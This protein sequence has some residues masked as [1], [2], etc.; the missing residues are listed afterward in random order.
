MSLHF[1]TVIH[2]YRSLTNAVID[3]KPPQTLCA[4]TSLPARYRDP[5]TGLP[6]ANAYAF[7][8][9]KKLQRGEYKWS[10]LAG[11]YVGVGVIPQPAPA[12]SPLLVENE[13]VVAKSGKGKEA[14]GQKKDTGSKVEPNKPAHWIGCGGPA[15][16]ARGVPARFNNPNAVVVR[17]ETVDVAGAG[18][19]GIGSTV[20]KPTTGAQISLGQ[21]LRGGGGSIMT[22]PIPPVV[23]ASM[24]V[25]TPIQT[26]PSPSAAMPAL[27][28]TSSDP[29]K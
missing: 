25:A 13:T 3:K 6:Y 9:L 14:A 10:K 24:S 8:E 20:E 18:S 19:N 29:K 27:V 12:L 2:S 21:T 1:T 15:I 26:H 11:C 28:A 23:G 4:I 22:P 16:V 17:R 7:R 5:T